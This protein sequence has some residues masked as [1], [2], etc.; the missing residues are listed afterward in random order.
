MTSPLRSSV[1]LDNLRAVRTNAD[2]SQREFARALGYSAPY[3]N[4]I[5]QGRRMPSI[6]FIESLCAFMGCGPE[7]RKEW[8]MLAAYEHG[9]QVLST[10]STEEG[11]N[12]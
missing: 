5:E 12:G 4:D 9:W 1:F 6:R 2:M 8:H 7:S 11:G 3:L 10:P